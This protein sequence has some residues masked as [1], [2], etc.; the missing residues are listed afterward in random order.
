[1]MMEDFVDLMESVVAASDHE[2][3]KF[4]DGMVEKVM[5]QSAPLCNAV[6]KAESY[7]A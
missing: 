2:E 5:L 4:H 7:T 6:E 1:M 3:L